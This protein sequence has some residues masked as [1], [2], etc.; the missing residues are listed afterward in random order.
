MLIA[1]LGHI[2]EI[3]AMDWLQPNARSPHRSD[4]EAW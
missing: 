4:S 1:Q 2:I 3:A